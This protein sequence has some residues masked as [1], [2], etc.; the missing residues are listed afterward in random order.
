M[1]EFANLTSLLREKQA[2]QV[3]AVRLPGCTGL[4]DLT[5]LPTFDAYQ[6]ALRLEWDWAR[7]LHTSLSLIELSVDNLAAYN[8]EHGRETGDALLRHLAQELSTA[9]RRHGDDTVARVLETHFT[10]ILPNTSEAGAL[11]VARR[12]RANIK[13]A[14]R[15]HT[16]DQLTIRVSIATWRPEHDATWDEFK[17]EAL[18][19]RGLALTE[20]GEH[21]VSLSIAGPVHA[22]T[23]PESHP[24]AT[25]RPV[26]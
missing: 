26:S 23:T 24:S 10:V 2:F 11:S 18:A 21:L 8:D 1:P 4:D 12:F 6:T 19:H 17:L 16:S 13:A 9:V 25:A 20:Q 5:G 7:R 14:N 15:L 3:D 22:T